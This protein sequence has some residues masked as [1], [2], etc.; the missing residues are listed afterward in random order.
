[1]LYNRKLVVGCLVTC[2]CV[3]LLG[4]CSSKGKDEDVTVVAE[5]L[6]M[7]TEAFGK[8]VPKEVENIIL[9][10]PSKVTEIVANNGAQVTKGDVLFKIDMTDYQNTL[11]ETALNLEVKKLELNNLV[12]K[13]GDANKLEAVATTRLLAEQ[14]ELSRLEKKYNN[15][16]KAYNDGTDETL[17]Q[18]YNNITYNQTAYDNELIEF[19]NSQILFDEGILSSQELLAIERETT[20]S[21]LSLEA[22]KVEYNTTKRRSLESIEAMAYTIDISRSSILNLEMVQGDSVVNYELKALEVKSL[23]HSYDLLNKKLE[24][25]YIREDGS[26][27]CHIDSGIFYDFDLT[28]GDYISGSTTEKTYSLSNGNVMEVHTKI[29]EDFIK[30]I[31]L[32]AS[33]TIIPIASRDSRYTGHITYIADMAYS[34]GGDAVIEV[35]V[36]VEDND[37]LLKPNYS[38]DVEIE[39]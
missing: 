38:V 15:L 39:H 17:V 25:P 16:R 10:F 18:L 30:D 26:V 11:S 7:S 21:A 6:I 35:Y 8:I 5:T 36:S 23:E 2:L 27:I 22:A 14:S 12:N 32:G 13:E 4:G 1:M 33:T 9:E 19:E 34:D 3:G 37:G 28:V 31:K 29:S 20:L 24:Q